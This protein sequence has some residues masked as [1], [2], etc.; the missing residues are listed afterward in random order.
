MAGCF[1]QVSRLCN[2]RI[3]THACGSNCHPLP[4]PVQAG[5][6]YQMD[7][8]SL[9]TVGESRMGGQIRGNTFAAHYRVITEDLLLEQK[10]SQ[11]HHPQHHPQPN[12]HW[13]G[14]GGTSASS[15]TAV[16]VVGSRGVDGVSSSRRLVTFSNEYGYGGA[17]A[18]F[19][20]FDE[21]SRLLHETRHPL[22]VR[23]RSLQPLWRAPS[24]PL[25]RGFFPLSLPRYSRLRPTA[26]LLS[27]SC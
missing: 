3:H 14:A 1:L 15:A 7:P 22:P 8:S 20:E 24:V 21:D 17:S 5:L 10:V 11:E 13:P 25:S 12:Q 26:S 18:V 16:R 6:P 4:R 19:Y 23:H 2:T 27:C 9:D